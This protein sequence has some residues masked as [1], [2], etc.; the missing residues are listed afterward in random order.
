MSGLSQKRVERLA[1]DLEA[2]GMSET[3][4]YH[5]ARVFLQTVSKRGDA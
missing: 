3:Q 4:A 2:H 5:R 1:S